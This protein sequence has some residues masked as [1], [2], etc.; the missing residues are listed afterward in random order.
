MDIDK[1]P[2]LLVLIG[3]TKPGKW[4]ALAEE[5]RVAK[6]VLGAELKLCQ[7]DL[8]QVRSQLKA[9]TLSFEEAIDCV[10]AI[11]AEGKLVS[12]KLREELTLA[13]AIPVLPWH[14]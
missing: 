7:R 1:G 9:K 12:R 3:S 10:D 4:A 8:D 13:K 6:E 11:R 2:G 14:E 5:E